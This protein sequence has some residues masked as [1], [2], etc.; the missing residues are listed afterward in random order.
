MFQQNLILVEF[1]SINS[2][3][4][5]IKSTAAKT[6]LQFD[7]YRERRWVK[8]FKV[9]SNKFQV[10]RKKNF[11]VNPNLVLSETPKYE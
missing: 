6:T 10:V 11:K 2:I 1:G 5:L 8:K 4:L 7:V 3:K 9:R